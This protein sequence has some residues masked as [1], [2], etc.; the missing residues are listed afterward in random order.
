M[1][2]AGEGG[3]LDDDEP[4]A[5]PDIPQQKLDESMRCAICQEIYTM[6]VS[7]GTCTHTCTSAAGSYP[8][9]RIPSRER[10]PERA[11][12]LTR[13]L[14]PFVDADCSLCIRRTLKE[15]K[16]ECPA[17]RAPGEESDL[18]PNH[19]LEVVVGAY[20]AARA[21]L[22]AAA[23]RAQEPLPPPATV[24]AA[25]TDPTPPKPRSKRRGARDRDEDDTPPAKRSAHARSTRRGRSAEAA[26]PTPANDRETETPPTGRR[27]TRSSARV[28]SGANAS[29]SERRARG[30]RRGATT[31]KYAEDDDEEEEDD[32]EDEDY[33]EGE[34]DGEGD[35]DVDA[36]PVE[37]KDGDRATELR[38]EVVDLLDED[39]GAGGLGGRQPAAETVTP[40]T[41]SK[42]D[43]PG[44]VRCPICD[45][46]ILEGL[47]NSHVDV[48]LTK[49]GGSGFGGGGNA[50]A[51]SNGHRGGSSPSRAEAPLTNVP[52]VMMAKLPKMVYHIM[53]D[54]PLKKLLADAG[55]ST[56]GRRDQLI[57]RHK[58]FTLRV[59]AT[60]DSGHHPNLAA[61]AREVGRL[62]RDRDRA[63]LLGTGG[64]G[65]SAAPAAAVTAAAS[66]ADVFG[67][68]IADVRARAGAKKI[69]EQ[70]DVRSSGEPAM[71]KEDEDEDEAVKDSQESEEY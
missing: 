5:W 65:G 33:G 11:S 3:D 51:A 32:V 48:C 42:K 59:N 28:A 8:S 70:T 37:R 57:A 20:R 23:R 49:V 27:G 67:K 30:A 21:G 64:L 2:F 44:T 7:F 52:A 10:P 46:G 35:D 12:A 17:C 69:G 56:S 15:F 53:K 58:E 68:L 40:G 47:I 18:K 38:A 24:A 61:I 25:A 14:H 19:A 31:P 34:D 39:G 62:E 71:A 60:I 54:K 41:S 4:D 63:G 9:Y 1:S 22:L 66:K 43:R 13:S 26:T 36:S 16:M 55:L 6:P 45:V 50:K 29:T